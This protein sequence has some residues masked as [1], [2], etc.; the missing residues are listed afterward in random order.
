MR[1]DNSNKI[2]GL[3]EDGFLESRGGRLAAT[4]SGRLVLNRLIGELLA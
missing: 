1:P 3:I 4:E 2:N